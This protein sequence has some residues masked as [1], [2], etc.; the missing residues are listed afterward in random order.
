MQNIDN[1]LK[2]KRKQQTAYLQLL[3]IYKTE[4]SQGSISIIDFTNTIRDMATLKQK[5][6][7]L[8]MEKQALINTY[9]YWTN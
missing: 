7:L 1:Q 2:M 5:I 3:E 8:E 9:N 4:L 6:I